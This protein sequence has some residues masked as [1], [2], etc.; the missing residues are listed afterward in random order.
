MAQVSKCAPNASPPHLPIVL[1]VGWHT[2]DSCVLK[3]NHKCFNW[4]IERL[5]ILQFTVSLV[6]HGSFSSSLNDIHSP[7]FLPWLRMNTQLLISLFPALD[8]AFKHVWR[9]ATVDC[10]TSVQRRRTAKRWSNLF[11]NS[12]WSAVKTGGTSRKTSIWAALLSVSSDAEEE[13]ERKTYKKTHQTK[14]LHTVCMQAWFPTWDRGWRVQG[15]T[16]VANNSA[17]LLQY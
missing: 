6:F 4:W 10:F 13:R 16:F 11:C 2:V 12:M 15:K 9:P 14:H 8:P 7:Y 17:Q 3:G 5:E 1:W